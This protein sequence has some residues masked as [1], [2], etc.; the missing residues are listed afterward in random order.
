[1]AT[2]DARF[3]S[4]ESEVVAEPALGDDG[5]V[6]QVHGRNYDPAHDQR[7]MRRL[8]KRQELKVP[9]DRSRNTGNTA[10]DRSA[11]LSFLQHCRIR[12]SAWAYLG[13]CHRH[14]DLL[15]GKWRYSGSDMAG[16]CRYNGIVLRDVVDGEY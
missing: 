12:S 13:V 4:K 3:R 15:A 10:D 1:M 11:P 5:D 9:L 8:G 16:A 6:A 14:L 2:N 7:D